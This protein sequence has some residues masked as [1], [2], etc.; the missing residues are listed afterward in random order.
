MLNNQKNCLIANLCPI[1]TTHEITPE[2]IFWALVD[3]DDINYAKH[4]TDWVPSYLNELGIYTDE[5]WA[6]YHVVDLNMLQQ[7]I[8][9]TQDNLQLVI[10]PMQN[11]TYRRDIGALT[12]QNDR[13]AFLLHKNKPFLLE[14]L[15]IGITGDTYPITPL[16]EKQF[17]FP[18]TYWRFDTV[19]FLSRLFSTNIQ[20]ETRAYA[21]LLVDRYTKVRALKHHLLAN[22]VQ[23][24]DLNMLTSTNLY[25]ES[26]YYR[27]FF[28]SQKPANSDMIIHQEQYRQV[29]SKFKGLFLRMQNSSVSSAIQQLRNKAI[30]QINQLSELDDKFYYV[31]SKHI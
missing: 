1:L 8:L 20:Q 26:Y 14:D 5:L 12:N 23:K 24:N 16:H 3:I 27:A 28:V 10:A 4:A 17:I 29:L 15:A 19:T 11:L 2:E 21:N 7:Q 31:F 25:E 9:D 6:A 30:D 22:T 18:F 13:H